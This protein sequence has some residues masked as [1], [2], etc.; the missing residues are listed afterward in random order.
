VLSVEASILGGPGPALIARPAS[1][2]VPRHLQGTRRC[3]V[4]G[5][6]IARFAQSAYCRAA[7]HFFLTKEQEEK[8]SPDIYNFKFRTE[9][10]R[11]F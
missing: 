11:R 8:A 5:P 10:S 2:D 1:V 4:A 3:L 7:E 9:A 6:G